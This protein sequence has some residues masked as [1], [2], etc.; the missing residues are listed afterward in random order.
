MDYILY[1]DFINL[2]KKNIRSK[3]HTRIPSLQGFGDLSVAEINT[4]KQTNA[5]KNEMKI[6]FSTD[7]F[8]KSFFSSCMWSMSLS[9]SLS[10]LV[11]FS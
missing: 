1:M 8:Q 10:L 7:L 3:Q 11:C 2:F 5:G 9:V 6:K 4:K